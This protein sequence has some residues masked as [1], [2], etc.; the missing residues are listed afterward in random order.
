LSLCAE[1]GYDWVV[2][3]FEASGAEAQLFASGN[4]DKV[5]NEAVYAIVT[6]HV[7]SFKKYFF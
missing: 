2:P 5:S 7:I 4:T 3:A 1:Y 6:R